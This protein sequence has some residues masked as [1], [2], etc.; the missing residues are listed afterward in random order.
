MAYDYS[1]Y[2]ENWKKMR[3]AMFNAY[4]GKYCTEGIFKKLGHKG[5]IQ[6]HH[7]VP[8]SEANTRSEYYFLNQPWNL[9]PCCEKHHNRMHD[10]SRSIV[11]TYKPEKRPRANKVSYFKRF[12]WAVKRKY[13]KSRFDKKKR[14]LSFWKY[15]KI[16]ERKLEKKMY[17]WPMKY[18]TDQP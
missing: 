3:R 13:Y 14:P 18:I 17:S 12:T 5:Y 7:H 11:G 10:Y 2:P 4:G 8:L 1:K 9:I 15:W 16:G 6:V